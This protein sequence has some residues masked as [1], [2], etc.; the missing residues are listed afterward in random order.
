ME[1]FKT[2]AVAML[3]LHSLV[4]CSGIEQVIIS[5]PFMLA[6]DAKNNYFGFRPLLLLFILICRFFFFLR[7]KTLREGGRK[8]AIN[9]AIIVFLICKLA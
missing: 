6:D 1:W 3:P 5:V 2:V 9:K 8:N 7:V 4:Q